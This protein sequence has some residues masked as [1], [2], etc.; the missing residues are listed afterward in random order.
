MQ[1]IAPRLDVLGDVVRSLVP[2]SLARQIKLVQELT[3]RFRNSGIFQQL[4]QWRRIWADMTRVWSA[5]VEAAQK[6]TE[7]FR[8]TRLLE[9]VFGLQKEVGGLDGLRDRML[10]SFNFPAIPGGF[11]K[12]AL[13]AIEEIAK[14]IEEFDPSDLADA[15]VEDVSEATEKLEAQLAPVTPGESVEAKLDRLVEAVRE[16]TVAVRANKDSL[17][18]KLFWDFLVALLV[19]LLAGLLQSKAS[20]AVKQEIAVNVHVSAKVLV[21]VAR[22]AGLPHRFADTGLVDRDVQIRARPRYDSRYMGRLLRGD[23]VTIIRKARHWSLVLHYDPKTGAPTEGWILSRN[24]K[25]IR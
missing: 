7:S 17:A 15:T 12:H 18:E 2:E 6:F 5:H 22:D 3:D 14:A 21:G 9:S 8:A 24:L 1:A 4:E 19:N 11:A 20:D 13:A 10:K 16:N 23:V 25:P